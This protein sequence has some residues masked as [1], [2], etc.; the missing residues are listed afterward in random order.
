MPR[1]PQSQVIGP[2]QMQLF[3]DVLN[4]WMRR[5]EQMSN[6]YDMLI[7]APGQPGDFWLPKVTAPGADD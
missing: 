7:I 4:M 3:M 6:H 1:Q 5:V 2:G